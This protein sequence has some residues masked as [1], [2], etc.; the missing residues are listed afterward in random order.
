MVLWGKT[1]EYTDLTDAK[2]V[3]CRSTAAR[4]KQGEAYG[5]RM[6]AAVFAETAHLTMGRSHNSDTLTV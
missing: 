4:T 1:V 6:P 2:A 5:N 3:R